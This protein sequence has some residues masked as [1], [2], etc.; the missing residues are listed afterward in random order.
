VLFRSVTSFPIVLMGADYWSGLLDWLRDSVLGGGKINAT[1]L[2]MISV[3][4]DVDDAVRIMVEA[5]EERSGEAGGGVHHGE[6]H[7]PE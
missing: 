5:R 1:D 4:D 7:Q 3:T 2:D 6:P